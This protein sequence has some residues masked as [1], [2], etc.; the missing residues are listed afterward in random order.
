MDCEPRGQTPNQLFTAGLLRLR[1]SG[2]D[3]VDLFDSV[4]DVYGVAKKGMS[5]EADNEEGVVVPQSSVVLSPEQMYRIQENVNL[6][7][8]DK[9][10]G[11]SLCWRVVEI[12]DNT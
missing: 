4:P 5:S 7:S 6:L 12:V 9:Y 10:Y 2:M 3:A 11:I 8:D 1:F